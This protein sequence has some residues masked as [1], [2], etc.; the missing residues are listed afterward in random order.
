MKLIDQKNIL[1]NLLD[2]TFTRDDMRQVRDGEYDRISFG[3]L[4]TIKNKATGA[5]ESFEYSLGAAHVYEH[6]TV[7]G[8]GTWE[9]IRK[10][11]SGDAVTVEPEVRRYAERSN[12][13]PQLGSTY[14][15][16]NYTYK[17][18]DWDRLGNNQI[19]ITDGA[20]NINKAAMPPCFSHVLN[21]LSSDAQML[22]WYTSED[23]LLREIAHDLPHSKQSA[24]L[25]ALRETRRKINNLI[26]GTGL[27]LA[28]LDESTEH[29]DIAK[30]YEQDYELW[31]K[32]Q[33]RPAKA[34]KPIYCA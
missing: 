22:D 16:R 14:G 34:S 28:D 33:K 27:Q 9:T 11:G 13:V 4:V 23:D 10:P 12:K 25:Q 1:T 21:C 31:K 20:V 2:V 26:H 30:A 19:R 32:E 6:R 8:P 24:L 5:T 7:A 18:M 3:W 29:Q 15:Y 17:G